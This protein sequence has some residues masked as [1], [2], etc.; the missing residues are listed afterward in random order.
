MEKIPFHIFIGAEEE[1]SQVVTF[2]DYRQ[3]KIKEKISAL[4]LV[5]RCLNLI[6]KHQ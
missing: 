4:Q 6:E 1:S 5:D 2:S 3:S